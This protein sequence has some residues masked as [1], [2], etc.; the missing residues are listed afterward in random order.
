MKKMFIAG[1]LCLG[2]ANL[3]NAEPVLVSGCKLKATVSGID[4]A[5]IIGITA[6]EG[7]GTVTCRNAL[8]GETKSQAVGIVLA[9][10]GVGPQIAIPSFQPATLRIYSV[11]AGVTTPNAMFGEYHFGDALKLRFLSEQASVGRGVSV[12]V[13]NGRGAA[14]NVNLKLLSGASFGLGGEYG[15]SGMI[16]M[17]RAQ[18][19]AG[20][21]RSS[22]EFDKWKDDFYS[23]RNNP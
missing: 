12:T 21:A 4:A 6:L 1:V 18:Y 14:I 10:G 13:H 22:Q 15:M 16:V 3:A 11:N 20:K 9:G 2:L 19:R 17:S 23:G 8:T 5:I 7:E